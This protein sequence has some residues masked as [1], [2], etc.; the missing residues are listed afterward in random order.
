V[1]L[2]LLRLN[3]SS[4]DGWTKL[5]AGEVIML[6]GRGAGMSNWREQY[7]RM[8]RWRETVARDRFDADRVQDIFLAFVQT[9]YHMVDWLE[10]DRSQPIRREGADRH[11]ANSE[12]LS[13]CG[14]LCIGAKHARLEAELKENKADLTVGTSV[15]GAYTLQTMTGET[16]H[17]EVNVVRVQL[18]WRDSSITALEFADRCMD[19]WERLLAA[20]GVIR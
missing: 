7:D 16:S 10:L 11:V 20:R 5:T 14:A 2:L 6:D 4:T 12:V 8:K 13:L 1:N 17:R 19:D 3:A 18:E 15:L 9:C